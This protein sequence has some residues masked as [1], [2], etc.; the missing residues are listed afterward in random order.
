M[1]R[2]KIDRVLECASVDEWEAWLAKHHASESEAWLRLARKGSRAVTVSRAEALEVALCY[3]WIDGQARSQD[4]KYWLQRFT[5]RTRRSKWS[6]INCE[7]A[8]ALIREGK[9]Q[10]A[11]LAAVEAAKADGRWAAAYAP[12]STIEVP[13]DLR[14][15][16]EQN[17]RAGAFFRELDAQNRYAILY[18][19]HDA[20]K[21]ET[22]ARRIEKF[23]AM[24]ARGETIH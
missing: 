6:K 11:G 5:P 23:V 9:M 2:L 24:L 13:P 20:K 15:A 14:E 22:R 10:P 12:P 19:I 4:E 7:A 18:R 3:G 1:A 17:P 8:D 21:P 16:L